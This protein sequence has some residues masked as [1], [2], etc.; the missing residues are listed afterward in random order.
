[1]KKQKGHPLFYELTKEE[2]E[3]HD[4]KN[5]DYRSVRDPLANFKRV[6]SIMAL[7]PDMVW[8]TPESV[9]V[10]YMF[11]QLDSYLSLTERGLEGGVENIS[12]RLR[13]VSIYAKLIRILH[14][15]MA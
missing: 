1:M 15:E 2:V 3:L 4:A 10:V 5:A 9:A 6:A 7:Y 8:A 11:K 14:E 12:T 13:D